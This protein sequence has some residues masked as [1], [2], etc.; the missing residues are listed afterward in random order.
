MVH[1]ADQRTIASV[2]SVVP[3]PAA[4]WGF[5]TCAVPMHVG[6]SH[7]SAGRLISELSCPFTLSGICEVPPAVL[8]LLTPAPG[9]PSAH[10]GVDT[11]AGQ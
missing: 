10:L 5:S 9:K 8:G 6:L 1:D 3:P 7:L 2:F 11:Q 4:L